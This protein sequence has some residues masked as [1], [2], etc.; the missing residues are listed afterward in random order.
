MKILIVDDEKLARETIV[1]MVVE[2][3]EKMSFDVEILEAKDGEE[4]LHII[5][6]YQP[7]IVIADIMMPN[8]NGI[9]LLSQVNELELP[10]LFIFVSGFDSFEYAQKAVSLGAFSY[11]LKPVHQNEMEEILTKAHIKLEKETKAV[12]SNLHQDILFNRNLKILQKSFMTKLVTHVNNT[13]VSESIVLQQLKEINLHFRYDCFTVMLIHLNFIA[14]DN[15][16]S[17]IEIESDIVLKEIF[18][19][20]N[21]DGYEFDVDGKLGYVLNFTSCSNIKEIISDCCNQVTQY[22]NSFSHCTISTGIGLFTSS[23]NMLHTS[24][25]DSTN[26]LFQIWFKFQSANDVTQNN[27]VYYE[28]DHVNESIIDEEINV[29]YVENLRHQLDLGGASHNKTGALELINKYYS[30]FF[31]NHLG[32]PHDLI[33]NM[34]FQTIMVLT[35]FLDKAGLDPDDILGTE[36]FLYNKLNSCTT[37]EAVLLWC[38]EKI[39]I[40]LDAT[41]SAFENN[42]SKLVNRVKEFVKTNIDNNVSLTMAANHIFMTPQYLSKIFHQVEG[43]NFVNYVKKAKIE[44]AKQLLKQGYKPNEVSETLGFSDT[45]YF[46]KVFKQATGLSPS[47]YKKI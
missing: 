40:A 35:T 32:L 3:S 5:Q 7:E 34:N 11:I 42:N 21:I 28:S 27:L 23:L 38:D 24:Y 10:T 44:R 31:N 39:T 47:S 14:E 8:L 12:I 9:E 18:L 33:S 6:G 45:K 17:R 26:A 16:R 43:D 22:L 25:R 13:D 36:L 37:A 46:F 15:E 19:K 1:S 41:K 29:N 2:F 20:N 4:A 30:I